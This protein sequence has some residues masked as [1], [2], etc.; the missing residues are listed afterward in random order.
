MLVFAAIQLL[1]HFNS[2]NVCWSRPPPSLQWFSLEVLKKK[3]K[4]K[5]T[6]QTQKNTTPK[7]HTQLLIHS[8][9]NNQYMKC[10]IS[11]LKTTV[12]ELGFLFMQA[13]CSVRI[14]WTAMKNLYMN[15]ALKFN[16]ELNSC[17]FIRTLFLLILFPSQF[18]SAQP[19]HSST[20]SPNLQ[21]SVEI[22]SFRNKKQSRAVLIYKPRT[23]G[24]AGTSCWTVKVEALPLLLKL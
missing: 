2:I 13:G 24:L 23:A 21:P 10:I 20:Q 17:F 3:K 11:A 15:S 6:Q 4:I 19:S 18:Q 9:N 14:A 22:R 5:N 7:P 1:I 12:R 16:D 8:L